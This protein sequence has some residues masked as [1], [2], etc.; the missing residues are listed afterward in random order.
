VQ[1]TLAT[2]VYSEIHQFI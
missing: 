1:A 2:I